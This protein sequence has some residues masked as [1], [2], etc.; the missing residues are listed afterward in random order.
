VERAVAQPITSNVCIRQS[1]NDEPGRFC[2]YNCGTEAADTLRTFLNTHPIDE[3]SKAFLLQRVAWYLRKDDRQQSMSVQTVARESDPQL[4]M[5]PSGV[6]FRKGN[7]TVRPSTEKFVAWLGEF[8]HTN[9]AI[10]VVEELRTALTFAPD[11]PHE[12]FEQGLCDLGEI[13]GFESRRPDREAAVGPDVLWM[14]G[15]LAVPLEAKN[16]L[17]DSTDCISKHTAGQLMQAEA[18]T[19]KTY[20]E[21]SVVVPVSVHRVIKCGKQA[22]LPTSARI[23][24]PEHMDSILDDLKNVITALPAGDEVTVEKAAAQLTEKRLALAD[25]VKQ[26]AARAQ[27]A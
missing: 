10:A 21:K 13:L 16:R 8:T 3:Y 24:T 26:R 19:Q 2:G 5:P 27:T 12:K 17:K 15:S 11:H 25:I 4:L 18:W 9:G 22:I 23:L 20:P 7:A 6:K 14:D 1:R